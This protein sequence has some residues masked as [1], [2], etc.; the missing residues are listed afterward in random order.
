MEA[1]PELEPP[2]SMGS[3]ESD[4]KK[5]VTE[6]TRTTEFTLTCTGEDSSDEVSATTTVNVLPVYEE[7]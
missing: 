6:I 1:N 7:F 2:L 4:G 5:E 3:I